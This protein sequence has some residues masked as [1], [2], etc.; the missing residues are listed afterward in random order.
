MFYCTHC[1][2]KK[3]CKI[4]FW[5]HQYEKNKNKILQV[6]WLCPDCMIRAK[7]GLDSFENEGIKEEHHSILE[8]ADSNYS[9]KPKYIT[10]FPNKKE[11]VGGMWTKIVLLG[12]E[13][14]GK[15]VTL[16]RNIF[17]KDHTKCNCCD[18]IMID[19]MYMPLGKVET[20]GFK[21]VTV[22]S[23]LNI[24]EN[25]LRREFEANKHLII[26]TLV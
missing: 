13:G 6:V 25:C 2:T 17:H 15:P 14:D 23:G 10:I 16:V 7:R 3:D 11:R 5:C 8:F 18:E 24:C 21:K 9:K 26:A 1:K 4:T 12:N 20:R 19:K 22:S